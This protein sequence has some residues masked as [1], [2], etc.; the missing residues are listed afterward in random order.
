MDRGY[1]LL[2]EKSCQWDFYH[3]IREC[4]KCANEKKLHALR[5]LA[6]TQARVWASSPRMPQDAVLALVSFVVQLLAK[7]NPGRFWVLCS[8]SV[9]KAFE[10]LSHLLTRHICSRQL[11]TG[12]TPHVW[13]YRRTE[14]GT[15]N[16]RRWQDPKFI[17]L[18][19]FSV[20]D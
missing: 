6:L 12:R 11:G 16:S 4:V 19:W 5:C 1:V 10:M 18:G 13:M 8:T 17:C 3:I 7:R 14:Q 2:W 9:T 15:W 20:T